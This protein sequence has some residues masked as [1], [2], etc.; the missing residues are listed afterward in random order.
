MP[1][2]ALPPLSLATAGD[3]D[4][5]CTACTLAASDVVEKE[6]ADTVWILGMLGGNTQK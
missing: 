3:G 4:G 1:C 6:V 5:S 2:L